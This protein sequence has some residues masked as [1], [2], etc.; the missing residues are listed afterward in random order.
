MPVPGRRSLLHGQGRRH[1]QKPDNC[2]ATIP[3]TNRLW[4]AAKT[5]VCPALRLRHLKLELESSP[6]WDLPGALVGILPGATNPNFSLV[7]PGR[8]LRRRR[9]DAVPWRLLAHENV[10]RD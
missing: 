10:R 5:A 6:G 9:V 4:Y 8:E 7:R 1:R 2:A 3:I